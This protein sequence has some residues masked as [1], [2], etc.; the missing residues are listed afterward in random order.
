MYKIA[1]LDVG[2][3][4]TS[5]KYSYSKIRKVIC[6]SLIID[7]NKGLIIYLCVCARARVRAC[8]CVLIL[9]I[10]EILR[11]KIAFSFLK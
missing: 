2:L 9:Y 6:V 3:K 1:D 7:M 10:F 8:A 4:A 5:I 11:L